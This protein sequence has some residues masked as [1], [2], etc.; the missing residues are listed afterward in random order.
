M[1]GLI[2]DD[3]IHQLLELIFKSSSSANDEIPQQEESSPID[4][5]V[6]PAAEVADDDDDDDVIRVAPTSAIEY[7]ESTLPVATNGDSISGIN[8]DAE[9]QIGNTTESASKPKDDEPVP[10][11][12]MNTGKPLNFLQDDELDSQKAQQAESKSQSKEEGEKGGKGEGIM[13]DGFE[14]IPKPADHEVSYSLFVF[15]RL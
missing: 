6:S 4:N 5:D 10:H 2:I 14:V 13:E 11:P 12:S 7:S 9:A 15:E 3:H 8:T 1:E